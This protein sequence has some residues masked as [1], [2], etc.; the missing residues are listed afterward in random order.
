MKKGHVC[1]QAGF[2]LIE[3]LVVGGITA[4]LFTVT[5]YVLVMSTKTAKKS[6]L[7][8]LVASQANWLMVELDKNLSEAD[9]STISCNS[10]FVYF[11][12]RAYGLGTTLV[13][14]EGARVASESANTANLTSS[15]VRMVSCNGFFN[16][17]LSSA[18]PVINI[19]FTMRA[20][21]SATGKIED[22]VERSF[23]T[24][25]VVRE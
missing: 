10:N 24:T 6:Q 19:G 1:R 4:I 12:D 11:D 2:T 5:V 25:I 20:G 21:N 22:F 3:M 16:C 18:L 8:G 15:E 14:N 9:I 23:K 13:C 17:D 7:E